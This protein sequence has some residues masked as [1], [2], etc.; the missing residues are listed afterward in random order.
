MFV[1]EDLDV[2]IAVQQQM[3]GKGLDQRLSRACRGDECAERVAV[4][5]QRRLA[6]PLGDQPHRALRDGVGEKALRN[7]PRIIVAARALAALEARDPPLQDGG[8][9]RHAGALP[10]LEGGAED[11]EQGHGL[12][13]VQI[14][15]T[16]G[17]RRRPISSS[18]IA[19][20]S[21]SARS[22]LRP[23]PA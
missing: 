17:T 11:V 18:V 9:E 10:A 7:A 5:R 4:A 12:S 6:D 8:R 20:T 15:R 3:R 2:A 23:G 14:G 22:G 13:F 1:L 16:P 19:Q 21:A